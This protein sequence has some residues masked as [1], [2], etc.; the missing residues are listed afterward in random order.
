MS[1]SIETLAKA[2]A[3]QTPLL[4]GEMSITS[5]GKVEMSLAASTELAKALALQTPL[6]E[7][8]MAQTFLADPGNLIYIEMSLRT[9][10]EVSLAGSTET[11]IRALIK[12]SRQ[13]L[14]QSVTGF[15]NYIT[16]ATHFMFQ[17]V[18]CN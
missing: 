7:R 13:D 11:S 12:M 6:L 18:F 5:P 4:E 8:E 17:P 1:A 15:K 9:P 16:K 10:P 3:L 2:L 14:R